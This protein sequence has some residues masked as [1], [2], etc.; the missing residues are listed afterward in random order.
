MNLVQKTIS[1]KELRDSLQV[2]KN[3]T[4]KKQLADLGVSIFGS[5]KNQYVFE[6]DYAMALDLQYVRKLVQMQ[7]ELW[8]DIYRNSNSEKGV[9]ESVILIIC[10][11]N[12]KNTKFGNIRK[13]NFE[14]EGYNSDTL[15]RLLS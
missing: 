15:K 1:L 11:E 12:Q 4:L 5:G 2:T 9:I 3:E 14:D 7:P 6:Y 10:K 8:E 13:M